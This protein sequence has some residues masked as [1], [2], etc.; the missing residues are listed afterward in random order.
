MQAGGVLTLLYLQVLPE[1]GADP[2]LEA[3]TQAL[4]RKE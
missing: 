3:V 4:K 2:D 1:H